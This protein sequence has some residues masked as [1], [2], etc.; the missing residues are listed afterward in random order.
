MT[1]QYVTVPR[2]THQLLNL[3]GRKKKIYE[4]HNGPS[5]IFDIGF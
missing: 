4:K 5:V 1:W 2:E 3:S